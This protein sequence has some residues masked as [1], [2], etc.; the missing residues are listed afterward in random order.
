MATTTVTVNVA[1]S[2]NYLATSRTIS[3]ESATKEAGYITLSTNSVTITGLSGAT[4][5]VNITS[6]SGGTLS[7]RS[8]STSKVTATLSGTTITLTSVASGN[9]TITVTVGETSTHT[10][11]TATISVDVTVIIPKIKVDIPTQ[12]NSIT[13]DC[14]N[15]SISEAVPYD[16]DICYVNWSEY[17]SY[18]DAGTYQNTF[19][20]YDKDKYEW[21]DGTTTNKIVS[22]TISKAD[23]NGTLFIYDDYR[24][25]DISI[26]GVSGSVG[27]VPLYLSS[28]D[29]RYTYYGK[30]LLDFF[31]NQTVYTV[32]LSSTQ[33]M[34]VRTSGQDWVY[35]TNL[36]WGQSNVP[37]T[38]EIV[39]PETQN[40]KAMSL[41][42]NTYITKN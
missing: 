34:Q 26:R 2:Q 8:S 33:Y 7:V 42:V 41:T 29:S 38:I 13:Y 9:A 12:Q 30:M 23:L 39:A 27:N 15:H 22:W 17:S 36:P 1:E 16:S 21:S 40:L 24:N 28:T 5:T 19:I 11:A 10:S 35:D 25:Q 20:L 6:N 37:I 18:S 32:T 3:V 14:N 4:A 31:G